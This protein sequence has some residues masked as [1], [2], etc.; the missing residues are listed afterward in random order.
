MSH[1]KLKIC[2]MRNPENIQEIASLRPDYV[3]FIFYEKSKRFVGNDF[4]L[5]QPEL[6]GIK[7]VGVFVNSELS[8]V[9]KQVDKFGLNLVQLHGDETPEFCQKVKALG[10]AVIKAIGIQTGFDFRPLASYKP[11]VEYF[12]F[13]TKSEVVYGGTGQP[14]DWNLLNQYDQETSFFLSGGLG[15]E[16][17]I[18]LK[19]QNFN[20]WNIHAVDVNSKFEIAPGIKNIER[21][22]ALRALLP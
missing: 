2:G 19:A 21:L 13:D 17:I 11:F 22:R 8:Y 12:L 20:Q 14:F 10:I 4:T 9:Q 18:Y 3:G 16:E 1:V 6:A 15:L 5:D 7:K